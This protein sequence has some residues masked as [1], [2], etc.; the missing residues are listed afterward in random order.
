MVVVV[1][2]AVNADS[3]GDRVEY[4]DVV[5]GEGEL[6]GG[7]VLGDAFGPPS[8]GD[9][10]DPGV[11]GQQPGQRHLSGGGVVRLGEYSD[12]LQQNLIGVAVKPSSSSGAQ[13]LPR[14]G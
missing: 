13:A 9:G 11:L 6:G 7:G 1:P 4:C 2:V 12:L 3:S 5:G 10:H 14:N 8:T